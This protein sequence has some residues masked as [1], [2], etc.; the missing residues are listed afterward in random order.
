[1]LDEKTSQTLDQAFGDK[2]LIS[3]SRFS[4]LTRISRERL[5]EFIAVGTL[6][7]ITSGSHIYVTRPMAVDFLINGG[8][9]DLPPAKLLS[10][11]P[12]LSRLKRAAMAYAEKHRKRRRNKL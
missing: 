6:K 11:P 8:G 5:V 7:A 1:M 3:L 12:T 2:L 9:V 4:D 10:P